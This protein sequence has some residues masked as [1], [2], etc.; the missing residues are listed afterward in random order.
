MTIP[1]H[2]MEAKICN[3]D[4]CK[5]INELE[6]W[7]KQDEYFNGRKL[8]HDYI[9]VLVDDVLDKLNELKEKYK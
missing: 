5:I 2:L 9:T 6:E 1:K 8:R 3:K 7:L 4:N